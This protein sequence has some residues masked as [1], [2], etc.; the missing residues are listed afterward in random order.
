MSHLCLEGALFQL[1]GGLFTWPLS[2]V[3]TM[4]SLKFFIIGRHQ[5]GGPEAREEEWVCR[6]LGGSGLRSEKEVRSWREL[7]RTPHGPDN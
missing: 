4:R 5:Q 2:A 7:A 1:L 6:R 3:G